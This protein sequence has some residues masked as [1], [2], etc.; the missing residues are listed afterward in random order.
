M[1]IYCP[2]MGC[3]EVVDMDYLHDVAEETNSTYTAVM[4]DFQQRGCLALG[5][6]HSENGSDRGVYAEAL[7]DL[8]GDDLDGAAAM[9]EDFPDLFG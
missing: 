3:G 1:D 5:D 6:T 4:R 2:K 7:Y 8:L 9:M